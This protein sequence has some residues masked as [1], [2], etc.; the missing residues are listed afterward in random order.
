MTNDQF[1]ISVKKDVLICKEGDLTK[2]LYY[3]SSGK[4]MICSRSGHMLTPLAYIE[5][6]EYFGE[7]SF[8][9]NLTRSAD[10][11]AIQDSTLIKIP[12]AELK[13]QFPKWLLL[14]SKSMTQKLRLMNEVISSRGIRKKNTESITALSIDEQNYYY[15]IITA[16]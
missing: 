9:D 13:S 5:P 10:V 16:K 1:T 4:L 6:G 7:M 2:D 3:L 11:V 8:F 14:T 12:Q 15:K